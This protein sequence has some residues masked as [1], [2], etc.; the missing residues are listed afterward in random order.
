MPRNTDPQRRESS[1]PRLK[2]CP[3]CGGA[4]AFSPAYPVTRLGPG[5]SKTIREEDIPEP[6]RTV[7]AWTCTT[8][9]CRYREP[10]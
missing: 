1:Q 9:H 8:E 3:W 2:G 5:E 10:A 7:P 4:L 6:L